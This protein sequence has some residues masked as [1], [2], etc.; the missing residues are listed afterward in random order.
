[1]KTLVE[2]CCKHETI[3]V[4]NV[5]R[6]ILCGSFKMNKYGGKYMLLGMPTL[7]ELETLK[8]NINLCCK[9]DLDFIELN[10]NLP[11]YQVNKLDASELI[12]Y[13]QENNIFFTFHLPE[14]LE[15]AH[16]NKNIR[17]ANW[18][19]VYETIEFMK[20]IRSPIIN[21]HMSKGIY[22]TLPNEK[23]FLY[24]KYFEEY[25]VAYSLFTD[26]V[27]KRLENQDI[28]FMVENTGIYNKN[29]ITSIIDLLLE[30]EEFGLTWDIG[31]DFV[32]GSV[33]SDFIKSR[34]DKVYH[35]H[36]HDAKGLKDHLVL[37]DGEINL[38]KYID[39]AI[40]NNLT[41]V[42]ETKTVK[43]L[44]ESVARLR[45]VEQFKGFGKF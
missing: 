27:V 31:H 6:E 43:G 7:V 22:F 14:D 37:F 38:R 39:M 26:E 34:V 3:Y 21:M 12:T 18:E 29:F 13:Q 24:E 17:D 30:K 2:E 5:T 19:S 33:D 1:M 9:L 41:V 36:M 10:L 23:V 11:Q 44:M 32:G 16:F 28:R 4:I 25:K 20:K 15:I 40:N 45:G 35:I 42:V 8:E